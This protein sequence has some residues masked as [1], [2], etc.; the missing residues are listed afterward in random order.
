MN[1]RGFLTACLLMSRT[2]GEVISRHP[3]GST[4]APTKNTLLTQ[5][6]FLEDTDN[7]YFIFADLYNTMLDTV[8]SNLRV[9]KDATSFSNLLTRD[10]TTGTSSNFD[11]VKITASS[12]NTDSVIDNTTKVMDSF[13]LRSSSATNSTD[14]D[15]D[16]PTKD[17]SKIQDTIIGYDDDKTFSVHDTSEDVYDNV[18]VEKTGNKDDQAVSLKTVISNDEDDYTSALLSLASSAGDTGG[19]GIS[20]N[21][22]V[23]VGDNT[24]LVLD[25]K[26]PS[27]T[28]NDEESFAPSL[29][30]ARGV[31][32]VLANDVDSTGN[33]SSKFFT[34]GTEEIMKCLF[35]NGSLTS[36]E[37]EG[38]FVFQVSSL[39]AAQMPL[40]ST[41]NI[42]VQVPLGM[43]VQLHDMMQDSTVCS[44]LKIRVVDTGVSPEQELIS[45]TC[46][47]YNIFEIFSLSSSVTIHLT[48]NMASVSRAMFLSFRYTSLLGASRPELEVTFTSSVS[49]RG[50]G[51]QPTQQSSSLKAVCPFICNCACLS[52]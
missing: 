35:Q 42:K 48:S 24:T 2:V 12:D 8:S 17:T 41:C 47:L 26:K 37:E 4:T 6:P 18:N 11:I 25:D 50:H 23:D 10:G 33:G 27:G 52:V 28:S 19:A 49:G 36:A 3:S 7:E 29:L 34:F 51:R 16:Y 9:T 30:Q 5:A 38:A 32:M 31:A 45:W 46:T 14:V 22:S 1:L 44:N 13:S 40:M 21:R 43:V 15:N 39:Q 20:Q